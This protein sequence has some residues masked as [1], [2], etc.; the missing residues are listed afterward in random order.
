MSPGRCVAMLRL[1]AALLVT[2]APSVA[3]SAE[4]DGGT[5]D[6]ADEGGDAGGAPE[7][8]TAADVAGMLSSLGA[9]E[10]SRRVRSFGERAVPGLIETR[11][12]PSSATATQKWADSMLES[13]GKRSP[14]DAVQTSDNQLLARVLLA[15][16]RVRD[17]DALP[18]ALSFINSDRVVVR[19]AARDATRD[20]GPRASGRLRE[21]YAAL[22]G[23]QPPAGLA[24][25]DLAARLF[26]ACDRA[27][28]RDVYALLDEGLAKQRAGDLDGAVAAYDAVVARQ[29]LLDRRAEMAPAYAAYGE[30]LHDKDPPRALAR[31]REA[32]RLDGAGP[33]SDRVRG[34]I[35]CLQ[36]EDML[37]HGVEDP[38]PFERA[39]ALDPQ[40]ARARSLLDALHARTA[41]S[42]AQS[43]RVAVAAAVLLLSLAAML[44][45]VLRRRARG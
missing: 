25:S 35:A 16:A 28:L 36:G 18:V 19:T 2:F 45:V 27:R 21:A 23:E 32:L 11:G 13:L 6:A 34:A 7:D 10:A 24:A 15:Y 42:R 5:A 8:V 33:V 31:L 22:T 44:V 40:N 1:A 3:R 30:S 39:L 37:R 41:A 14:S 29:P 12:D 26:A 20:Y 9:A 43:T 4:G 38:A 17:F